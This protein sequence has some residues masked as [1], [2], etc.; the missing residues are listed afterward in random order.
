MRE[1]VVVDLLRREGPLSR[2]EIARR[3]E[4][5]KPTVS[6]IVAGLLEAGLV[7]EGGREAQPSGRP[8]RL[9]A[10]NGAAGYVVGADVGG[11]STRAVLAD[12][13]GRTVAV[14]REPTDGRSPEA[15][16]AQLSG[17]AR[18]LAADGGVTGRVAAV[19]IATPGVIDP[20]RRTIALAPN[21]RALE[22]DGFLDR[23]EAELGLP[24]TTL[25]DVNAATLG[26]LHEG[27][28]AGLRDVAYV[29][30]GTGLGCGLV[31]GGELR[32]GF[33]GRAGELGLLPYPPGADT[34]LEDAVSGAGLRRRH[35][36]F[37]GSGGPEAAFAEADHGR[38]PGASLIDAFLDDLAWA[39]A[40]VSTLVDPQRIVLGGGI[41]LRCASRLGDIRARLARLAGFDVDVALARLGD[42]AGLRGAV[43]T[44]LE[45]ARLVRRWLKGGPLVDVP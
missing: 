18:R 9:L 39:L 44:A 29:G 13:E 5:S 28:A 38:E 12:L 42:E 16:V 10:F 30:I 20:A 27:A 8:G 22:A 23:L 45:P 37:G 31:L 1:Q 14:L 36:G 19:A 33:G 2:A 24:L 25:N 4:V 40:A 3:C 6:G 34:T 7:V 21:L 43:A 32:S 26:E 11:T 35:A 41:G 17:L 15:L